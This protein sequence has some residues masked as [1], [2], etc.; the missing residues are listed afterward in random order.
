RRR[1]IKPGLRVLY[2]AGYPG[3]GTIGREDTFST[4][5]SRRLNL[6]APK[7]PQAP[8][9]SERPGQA[10][11]LLCDA[12]RFLEPPAAA[13]GALA[14]A[15]RLRRYL[16]QLVLADPLQALLEIHDPRRRELDPLVGGRRPHVRELLLFG[17]VDVEV[18]VTAVL[19]DDHALVDVRARRDEH[20]PARLQVI[21]GVAG[22]A[23]A[24][25]GDEGAV[26]TVGDVALPLVPPVE[27]VIEQSGAARIGEELRPIAD[28][29]PRRDAV[30]EA[31]APGS[32]VHH[33][34]HRAPAGPDLLGHGADVLLGDVDDEV[35]HRLERPAVLLVGDDGG[36]PH[37]ELEALATHHLD[38]DRQLE[39]APSGD[40]KRV[41][42][43][44]LFAPDCGVDAVFL[45]QELPEVP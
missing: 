41:G 7:W 4:P 42:R 14:E 1:R 26:L 19:A 37:L 25:V 44:G 30:L 29:P 32:V 23:A 8:Q 10:V 11:A 21:D 22:R 39:L 35:F 28:Q 20:R 13:Q 17:D 9:R 27:Q 12:R 3:D 33:L 18:V 38:E 6:G 40:A 15:E 43:I 36:L 24:A 31:H 45:H 5:T 34:D 16:E 2:M